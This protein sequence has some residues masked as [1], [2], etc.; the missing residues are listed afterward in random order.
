[1]K[2]LNICVDI[3][4]TITEPFYWL[5]LANYY[6]KKNIKEEDIKEYEIHKV[7]GITEEEYNKFYEV[8]DEVIHFTAKPRKG[9]VDVLNKLSKNHNIYY[10]SA[11]HP[12]L[13][14]ITKAWLDINNMPKGNIYLLGSHD[15]V[16]KAKDLNCDV[17]I[18]DRYENAVDLAKNGFKV[19][20]IDCSYNKKPLIKGIERVYN[21]EQI[22]D[23][24]T[25]E[26]EEKI[27]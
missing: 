1:M 15:K 7:L 11:R 16:Q 10:V 3:D 22:L 17:F 6:F 25:S 21:W 20:L 27:A 12:K 5:E 14:D 26:T 23:I 8:Y 18:E 13:M 2:R 4:G 24:I 9:A 19:L